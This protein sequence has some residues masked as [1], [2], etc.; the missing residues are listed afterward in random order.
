MNYK[1]NV[2]KD[3][4]FYTHSAEFEEAKMLI[5]KE[6]IKPISFKS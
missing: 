4:R 2:K 6:E 5:Q 1:K 3:I